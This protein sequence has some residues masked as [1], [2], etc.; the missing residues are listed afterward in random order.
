ML[1]PPPQV[2]VNLFGGLPPLCIPCTDLHHGSP[3]TSD[4][5]PA[6][7]ATTSLS[8]RVLVRDLKS[9]LYDI[10][11]I[12]PSEQR[13]TTSGGRTLL[14]DRPLFHGQDGGHHGCGG[15]SECDD[16]GVP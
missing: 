2:V 8:S 6:G 13:I 9:R 16:D 4:G 12:P 14:D 10:L 5:P 7:S 11:S 3:E 15:S 1:P